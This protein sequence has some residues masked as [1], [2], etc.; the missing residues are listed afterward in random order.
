MT[1]TPQAFAPPRRPYPGIVRGIGLLVALTIVEGV[2]TIALM[3]A[4]IEK[5]PAG[6]GAVVLVATAVVLAWGV[7][8]GGQPARL[9]LPL[10]AVP[11]ALLLA[12]LLTV[13][14]LSAVVSELSNVVVYFL[15]PPDWFV[16]MMEELVSN[17][18]HPWGSVFAAVIAAPVTEELI[19]RGLFL[20]GFLR[21]YSARKAIVASALLFALAHGNPWQFPVALCMGLLLGWC[22][23]RT[24]SLIP[25][26]VGHVANNAL[27]TGLS[28]ATV[29]IPGYTSDL[30]SGVSHQPWWFDGAGVVVTLAGL[31][32]LTRASAGRA[33]PVAGP[34]P[35]PLG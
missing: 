25:G 11:P 33:K 1:D 35:D 10:T 12:L 18:D 5:D 13:L 3:F 22:R 30:A 2:L 26:M 20:H 34:A 9:V 24:G 28:L 14:G 8:R 32:W 17:K 29:E 15:P 7:W 6:F 4:G 23:M 31:M 19:F 21:R 27:A 16:K